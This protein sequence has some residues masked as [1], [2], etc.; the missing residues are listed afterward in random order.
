ML[1]WAQLGLHQKPCGLL[2]VEHYFDPLL[3]FLDH[4]VK[5]AFVNSEYLKLIV[6]E[7]DC[8]AMLKALA[9]FK[10]PKIKRYIDPDKA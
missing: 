6:M 8:G 10:P 5:E 2:N 1:T 9:R 3:Q 4:A 7:K